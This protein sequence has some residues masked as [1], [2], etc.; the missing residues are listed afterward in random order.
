MHHSKGLER[1]KYRWKEESPKFTLWVLKNWVKNLKWLFV[2][3]HVPTDRVPN[4]LE[5]GKLFCL[6]V[7]GKP[8]EDW[9]HSDA[10]V[11]EEAIKRKK[12]YT[13]MKNIKKVA[14]Q[15]FKS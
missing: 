7:R 14:F 8:V 10:S 12:P 1:K 9:S 4:S 11:R 15:A 13:I 3:L 5:V 2:T 6:R